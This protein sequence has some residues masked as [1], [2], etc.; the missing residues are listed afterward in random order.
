MTFL[1][2]SSVIIVP[3]GIVAL[4]LAFRYGG[5]LV[6]VP[7]LSINPLWGALIAV[8]FLGEVFNRQIG[9]GIITSIVGIALLTYGQYVGAP[10]SPLWPLG[11]VFA[12]ITAF[13]WALTAN[14]RR[15]FLS[16]DLDIFWMIGINSSVA[17]GVLIVILI[18]LGRIY[19]LF[20]FSLTQIWQLLVSGGLSAAGNF[21]LTAALALATVAS[22]TTLKSLDIVITSLIAVLFLG[23]ILNLPIVMGIILIVGGV[24][25]VQAGKMVPTSVAI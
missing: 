24:F 15:Y 17:V 12:L 1:A 3:V 8:P 25:I 9:I 2:I 5:I 16:E 23:E 14:L 11:V 21:T 20:E 18:G 13:S 6:A 22:V 10:V 19:T 4:Y 7:I